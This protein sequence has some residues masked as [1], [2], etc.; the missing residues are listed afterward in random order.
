[1]T[2]NVPGKRAPRR[3]FRHPRKTRSRASANVSLDYQL[4]VPGDWG[5]APAAISSA[6]DP[7]AGGAAAAPM[8]G[9]QSVKV[10]AGGPPSTPLGGRAKRLEDLII[11][12]CAL[13]LASPVMLMVALVIRLTTGGPALYSHTRVGFGGKPFQCYKFRSMVCN[14]DEVL[15]DYLARDPEAARQ[16]DANR[17]L[18]CDPRIT[19]LGKLLRKSSLDELPQLFNILRGEMSCV[20]PRPVVADELSRYGNFVEDYLATRP[21]LTGLWQVTGRSSTDYSNRVAL[22]SHYVRNWSLRADAVILVRTIFA[23]MRFDDAS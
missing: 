20:G 5:W 12:L 22:D 9:E 13:A 11:A 7:P 14:S 8:E 15:R 10:A 19:F 2:I 17:K 3:H 21:G 1:M 18:K 6:F 4:V 23:V 16:W